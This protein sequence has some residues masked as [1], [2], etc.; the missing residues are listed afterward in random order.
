MGGL[1][2]KNKPPSVS[3]SPATRPLRREAA[4]GHPPETPCHL[5]CK[6]R[7]PASSVQPTSSASEGPVCHRKQ[8]TSRHRRAGRL[9]PERF[10]MGSRTDTCSPL[11]TVLRPVATRW[12]SLR[13]GGPECLSRN[14]LSQ[15]VPG[16]SP[17]PAD[18]APPRHNAPSW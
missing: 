15:T 14:H 12:L 4:T 16:L 10:P 11:A 7:A 3:A 17:D 1:P 8:T 5:G 18:T 9:R 13:D 2:V 6:Q